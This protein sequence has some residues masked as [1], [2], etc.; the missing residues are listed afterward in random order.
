MT[1]PGKISIPFAMAE[2]PRIFL[3]WLGS[4]ESAL[5]ALQKQHINE[6]RIEHE[7]QVSEYLHEQYGHYVM[8]MAHALSAQYSHTFWASMSTAVERANDDYLQQ[9]DKDIFGNG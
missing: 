9:L 7:R 5:T 1:I 8:V 2:A 3:A 6:W 4:E